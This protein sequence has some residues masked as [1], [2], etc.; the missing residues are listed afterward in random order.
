MTKLAITPWES[1]VVTAQVKRLL[2]G[3]PCTCQSHLVNA[4]I[5]TS[6]PETKD[7]NT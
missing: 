3:A 4:A 5:N 6:T 7:E 1:L 2:H